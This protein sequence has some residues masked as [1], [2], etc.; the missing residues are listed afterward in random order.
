M[1]AELCTLGEVH[2]EELASSVLLRPMQ[3]LVNS[4]YQ[5]KMLVLP[6]ATCA[7]P[8]HNAKSKNQLWETHILKF[9]G[10]KINTTDS[11]VIQPWRG[12]PMVATKADSE[13]SLFP[14]RRGDGEGNVGNF[15]N[16]L[17]G[18]CSVWRQLSRSHPVFQCVRTT[19][20][21]SQRGSRALG[22]LTL[23]SKSWARQPGQPR[24]A[25]ITS[26]L[27]LSA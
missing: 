7:N 17:S 13:G 6:I 15:R 12:N 25:M 19:H 9:S 26:I 4:I 2:A 5:R 22:L 27:L 24:S 16:V 11:L 10:T 23:I 14:G 3:V 21:G 20:A 1:G 8:D 18:W